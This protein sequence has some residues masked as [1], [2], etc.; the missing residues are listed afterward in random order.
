[1]QFSVVICTYNGSQHLPRAIR[2]VL[3][4]DIGGRDGSSFEI[5]VVDD[6]STDDTAEVV[7]GIDSPLVRYVWRTNGG[8]SAARNTG[9]DEAR[10]DWIVF[11]DDDDWVEPDWLSSFDG[12]I[13]ERTGVVSCGFTLHDLGDDTTRTVL[14]EPMSAS[15]DGVTAVFLAGAFVTRRSLYQRIGGY[16]E[17]IPT[18]HQTEVS[19]RLVPEMTAQGLTAKAVHRPLLHIERRPFTERRGHSQLLLAG[20]EYLIEHHRDRLARSPRTLSDYHGVAAVSAFRIGD[21]ATSRRHFRAAVRVEPTNVR[22]VARFVLAHTPGLASLVWRR[23]QAVDTGAAPAASPGAGVDGDDDHAPT[24]GRDDMPAAERLTR[25]TKAATRAWARR[26]RG[27]ADLARPAA[28]RG[29][30]AAQRSGRVGDDGDHLADA[31]GWLYRAQDA[32]ADGGVAASYSV[33][34]GWNPSYPETTGYIVPTLLHHAEIAGADESRRRAWR[35]GEWLAS[36]QRP[37]GSIGRGVWRGPADNDKPAEVFNTGQVLFAYVALAQTGDSE[38]AGT[39]ADAMAD[40][41]RRAAAWLREHQDDDGAWTAH[42]LHG[43]AHTYYTRVTWALARAGLLLDEPEWTKG[44]LR[45]V[46]WTLGQRRDDGWIDLMS[47]TR[48]SDPLTHTLAYTIEG[49]LECGLVLD[50]EQSWTAGARACE[51]MARSFHAADGCRLRGGGLAATISPDWRG[52]ASYECPTGTAQLALCC[53]RVADVDGRSDLRE[54]ADELMRSVKRSQ[55]GPG[56][57]LDQRGGIPGS[58]PVWGR[59]ASFKYLNWAAKFTAD[60]LLDR[61]GDGLPRLRYG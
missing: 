6:G 3:E 4:Q 22:H 30:V 5:V 61:V 44:A 33:L 19:L 35:M 37:D 31:V 11:L 49:L 29:V 14:P 58:M 48:G 54:F 8:L 7:A 26:A 15:L 39:D 16:A 47:F 27:V 43:V 56:A 21:R 20:A 25:T 28:V 23:H 55:A 50:H 57:P 45:S 32:T 34:E 59:Y 12:A 52:S 46:E 1:M 24:T 60:A 38:G 40:A 13:D 10:G 51:Q 17:A 18:S 9:I 41:A 2:S 36:V 42:S 53:Q